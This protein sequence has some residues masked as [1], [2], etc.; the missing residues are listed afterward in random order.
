VLVVD[1]DVLVRRAITRVLTRDGLQVIEAA[2]GRARLAQRRSEVGV[3]LL[4]LDMPEL[5]GEA[6]FDELRAHGVRVP[7]LFLTGLC[8][9][10]R[11]QSLLERGARGILVKPCPSE[12]LRRAVRTELGAPSPTPR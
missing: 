4:D 5:D 8:D 6:T 11:R 7:V 12:L 2:D 10:A 1:D 3:I 9:E